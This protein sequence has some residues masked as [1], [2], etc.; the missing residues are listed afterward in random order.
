MSTFLIGYCTYTNKNERLK[1]IVKK[2]YK[3]LENIFLYLFTILNNFF[4]QHIV[5]LYYTIGRSFIIFLTN[6]SI[7]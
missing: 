2:P 3:P 1:L 6:Q 4:E 5:Q 7:L